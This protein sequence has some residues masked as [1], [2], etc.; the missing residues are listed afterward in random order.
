MKK[1]LLKIQGINVISDYMTK[2]LELGGID[3]SCYEAVEL[4]NTEEEFDKLLK[5]LP[6]VAVSRLLKR[7]AIKDVQYTHN[8]VKAPLVWEDYAIDLWAFFANACIYRRVCDKVRLSVMYYK[9]KGYEVDI[10]CHSL[11]TLITLHSGAS[12]HTIFC[13]ASPVGFKT[14][15]IRWVV[16]THFLA[17]KHKVSCKKLVNIWGVKDVVSGGM[18]AGGSSML[19]KYYSCHEYKLD[20]G[21]QLIDVIKEAK[22]SGC[23]EFITKH[24][25]D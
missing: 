12:V 15:P 11:G 7:R 20:C 22:R 16:N 19:S 1:V 18:R 14:H 23:L 21:H 25:N 6:S 3:L 10:L 8:E 5:Y 13:I 9:A 17:S 24:F 2:E 4:V